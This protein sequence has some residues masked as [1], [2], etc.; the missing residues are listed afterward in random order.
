MPRSQEA[1]VDLEQC[2]MD[3]QMIDLLAIRGL[4]R[5]NCFVYCVMMM[6][7]G[8]C[9]SEYEKA[10]D[11]EKLNVVN[12]KQ[13]KYRPLLISS[14]R[15]KEPPPSQRK[16][17]NLASSYSRG[18]SSK[19]PDK[20]NPLTN[21]VEGVSSWGS[22]ALI[23]TG[24]SHNYLTAGAMLSNPFHIPSKP[25]PPHFRATKIP[26]DEDEEVA[27]NRKRSETRM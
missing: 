20:P 4:S 17:P 13:Q 16:N 22:P 24:K 9:F 8:S 23:E 3:K 12:V 19:I 1:R 15:R 25:D 18:A 11:E 10:N 2:P 5:H 21:R 14:P 7:T 27:L 6:S 26:P